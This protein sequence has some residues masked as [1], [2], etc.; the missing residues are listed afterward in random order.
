MCG[1]AGIIDFRGRPIERGVLEDFCLTLAHRGPDDRGT[2]VFESPGFSVGLS[3]TRLAIIDPTPEARQPMTDDSGHRAISYN[4]ELYNYRE[5]GRTLKTQPRTASDTEVVLRACLERGK[6]AVHSFMGMWALAFVDGSAREGHLSR[7][8]LGIKPLYYIH[9]DGRLIFASELGA[10]R[11]VAGLQLEVDPQAIAIYLH[12]GFI[13]HPYTIYRR[14]RKLPPGHRLCFDASGPREPERYHVVRDAGC[15][16]D[17]VGPLRETTYRQATELV[18]MLVST[19]VDM[20]RVADVPLGA[21]LSGGLDS[22]IVTACLARVSGHRIKTF[23]IG[24]ADQ[25]RY[26]ESSYARLVAR[27]LETDHHEFPLT[28]RDVLSAIEPVLSHLGEPFGDSSLIPTALV[29]HY[30]RE[31]VTVALSGD[32][33]DELFGGYWRY[34]G[35]RYLKRFLQMPAP[36]RGLIGR[37]INAL[38]SGRTTHRLNKLRQIRKLL[39]A[40]E[41]PD[42]MSR[43]LRWAEIVSL[44]TAASLLGS[45]QALEARERIL[46]MYRDA[47]GQL[48]QGLGVPPGHSE[49]MLPLGDPDP[50][51]D[52]L[53]ADLMIGLPADMLFKV[54]I[55]SMMYGLEVR[56]P[57]LS[58]DLVELVSRLPIEYKLDGAS[59]KRILRDAFRR[60]LPEE[61]MNRPKMGFEVPV[62]EFLRTELRDTFKS[63]VTDD[64]LSGFGLDSAC[65]A[66]IYDEHV[67]RHEDH[68]E[69]LWSLFVL[70]H[71]GARQ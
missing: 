3:H 59:G 58:Q 42:E 2:W 46:K 65:V 37:M 29:S 60:E 8:P 19:A 14:V 55:A 70:C 41:A 39:K 16:H 53:L 54:D 15:V 33:G 64:A 27:H 52:V 63:L 57:L 50:L 48:R 24:Y 47:P 11:R 40:A 20:Q 44:D 68:S 36:L 43:H 34:Q 31:H 51:S 12:L 28:F 7:D 5:L 26:D 32:G 4:G 56:V 45:A 71:W 22:S 9:D 18:H 23:S 69:L 35:H 21:F 49:L 61:V 17:V 30:T 25:P 38:P 66:R 6:D 1:I 67:R 13:P 10:I 62:G